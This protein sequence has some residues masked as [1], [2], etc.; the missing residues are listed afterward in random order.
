[1]LKWKLSDKMKGGPAD[2]FFVGNRQSFWRFLDLVI[3]IDE[4]YNFLGKMQC[5]DKTEHVKPP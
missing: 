5:E 1:M 2:L 3:M 4:V